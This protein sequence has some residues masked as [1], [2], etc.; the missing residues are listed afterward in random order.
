[1]CSKRFSVLDQETA[2]NW[3]VCVEGYLELAEEGKEVAFNVSSYSAVVAL[4]NGRE[5][6]FGSGLNVVD[7]LY[8]GWSKVGESEPLEFSGGIYFLDCSE[9]LFNWRVWVRRVEIEN[10]DLC[11]LA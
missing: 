5:D 9:C 11:T 3:R 7:L 8:I 4:E 10:V 1:L 2:S 6:R